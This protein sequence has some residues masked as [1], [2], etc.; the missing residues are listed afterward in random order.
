[1]ALS[2]PVHAGT[3]ALASAA[4][5]PDWVNKNVGEELGR[6]FHLPGDLESIMPSFKGRLVLSEERAEWS[7]G[8]DPAEIRVVK[9]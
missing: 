6:P 9:E 2:A 8:P 3:R 1:M 4:I 7:A 5:F